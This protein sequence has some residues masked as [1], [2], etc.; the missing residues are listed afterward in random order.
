M[1]LIYFQNDISNLAISKVDI[2]KVDIFKVNISYVR[3]HARHGRKL[4][5]VIGMAHPQSPVIGSM[6]QWLP[7]TGVEL[8][9]F[10]VPVSYFVD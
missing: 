7:W 4:C 2:S 3:A 5:H 9:V 10:N 8:F 6:I 1:R